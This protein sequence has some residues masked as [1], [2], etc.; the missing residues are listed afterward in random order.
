ME[1]REHTQGHLIASGRAMIWT[2]WSRT[3][4]HNPN[5]C[6]RPKSALLDC[7]LLED[8]DGNLHFFASTM[9]SK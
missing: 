1:A 7:K 6:I 4:A 9:S 2:Q 3:Q 8:K 5:H